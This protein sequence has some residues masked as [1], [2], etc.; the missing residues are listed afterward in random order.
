VADWIGHASDAAVAH[1]T[2]K[3]ADV[4]RSHAWWSLAAMTAP[5]TCLLR[6]SILHPPEKYP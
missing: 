3:P 6:G 2:S 4:H 5:I 1:P